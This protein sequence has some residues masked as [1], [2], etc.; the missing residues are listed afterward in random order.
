MEGGQ[1]FFRDLY[2]CDCDLVVFIPVIRD[3]THSRDR[4][5]SHLF[6][7][8]VIQTDLFSWSVICQKLKFLFLWPSR[9]PCRDRDLQHF[10]SV[11]RD[12]TPPFP[13]SYKRVHF[14]NKMGPQSREKHKGKFSNYSIYLPL[15]RLQDTPDRGTRLP[16]GIFWQ[17]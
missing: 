5:F 13:P 1:G 6:M 10:I 16:L 3:S 14:C 15:V 7:W 12:W 2:F 11:I 17:A 9:S 4:D 8:F